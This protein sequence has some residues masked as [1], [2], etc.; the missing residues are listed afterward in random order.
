MAHVNKCCDSSH[1][2][3]VIPIENVHCWLLFVVKLN[4]TKTN[5][6]ISIRQTELKII[7]NGVHG[8]GCSHQTGKWHNQ[9]ENV[10]IDDVCWCVIQ[11][12]GDFFIQILKLWL[13]SSFWSYKHFCNNL[14]FE[15]CNCISMKCFS[16]QL[17]FMLW[18]WNSDRPESGKYVCRLF[19]KSYRY[20]RRF[21]WK[22]N[23]SPQFWWLGVKLC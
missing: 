1:G 9:F 19:E 7:N 23:I 12:F 10:S 16:F 5:F 14:R 11:Y 22:F 20:H 6:G 3:S 21:V 4:W 15:V 13:C 2:K 18:V 8:L 17:Q